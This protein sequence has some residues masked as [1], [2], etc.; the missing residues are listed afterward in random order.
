MAVAALV[1]WWMGPHT[2]P[3]LPTLASVQDAPPGGY[4]ATRTPMLGRAQPPIT[5]ESAATAP[6]DPSPPDAMPRG[7]P[8]PEAATA[9]APAQAPTATGYSAVRM[10]ALGA[11]RPDAARPARPDDADTSAVTRD[12]ARRPADRPAR[13]QAA[14]NASRPAL[15]VT[16]ATAPSGMAT[17]TAPAALAITTPA[18]APSDTAAATPASPGPSP[19]ASCTPQVLALGLCAAA[20]R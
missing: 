19:T 8:P 2:E 9:Q 11:L 1:V 12:S 3:E 6:R 4:A 15:P 14:R 18:A 10:P 13:T 16:V 5:L 20:S 7:L 17:A